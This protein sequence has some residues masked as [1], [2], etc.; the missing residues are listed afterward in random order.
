MIRL[1]HDAQLLKQGGHTKTEVADIVG[2]SDVIYFREVF[3][4]YYDVS[5]SKYAEV[6]KEVSSSTTDDME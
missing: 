4:R 2:F 6:G 5:P 1:K 3:K